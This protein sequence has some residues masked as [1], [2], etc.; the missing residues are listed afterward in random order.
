[1]KKLLFAVL[2]LFSGLA[3]GQSY[4]PRFGITP[5]QDNTGRVLTFKQV[6]AATPSAGVDTLKFIPNAWETDVVSKVALT[7]S[8]IVQFKS[9]AYSQAGDVAKFYLKADATNRKVRFISNGTNYVYTSS[10]GTFITILATKRG[11]IEFI[12]SGD[13]WIET[14]RV[15]QP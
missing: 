15:L 6:A 9:N 10:S 11:Y 14:T 12:F 1:M 4:T 2:I 8:L 5:N 3:F 7:D 13:A